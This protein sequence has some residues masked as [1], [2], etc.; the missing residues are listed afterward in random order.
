MPR[1]AAGI[2]TV[3][4][5][6]G[7]LVSLIVACSVL[8]VLFIVKFTWLLVTFNPPCKISRNY[9]RSKLVIELQIW[10]SDSNVSTEPLRTW[11]VLSHAIR[12]VSFFN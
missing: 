3:I 2:S 1:L 12:K 10:T 5:S 11:I 4:V 6:S 7:L 9:K 8:E